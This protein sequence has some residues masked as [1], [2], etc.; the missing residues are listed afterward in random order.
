MSAH[1][2][3]TPNDSPSFAMDDKLA[4]KFDRATSIVP[5]ASGPSDLVTN[6][7]TYADRFELPPKMHEL[8]II[9]G[10]AALVNG[11]VTIRNGAQRIP[12]D[13]WSL[14]ISDSGAGRN[15]LASVFRDLLK[16]CG[17]AERVST[18]GWGSGQAMQEY[19]AKD[20][21]SGTATFH[22]WEEMSAMMQKLGQKS[23]QGA[24]EWIT[25]LYDNFETPPAVRYRSGKGG[26]SKTPD[27][28]F[29]MPPRTNFLALTSE[30]WFLDATNQLQ[31]KGGFTP[32]WCP[33]IVREPGR[34]IATP[35]EADHSLIPPMAEKMKQIA[36]CAGEMRVT[37]PI[38]EDYQRW[39][40]AMKGRFRKHSNPSLAEPFANRHRVHF[41]KLW[42]IYELSSSASLI[43]TKESFERAVVMCRQIEET[44]LT[45]LKTGFSP[46]GIQS[47]QLEDA[48]RAKGPEG[49]SKTE[50]YALGRVS[51]FHEIDGRVKMLIEAGIAIYFQRKS[52]GRGRPGLFLV[53]RDHLKQHEKALPHD[54]RANG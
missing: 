2:S 8:T 22:V 41:L 6:Y 16:E 24:L 32:R 1:T 46:E 45:L 12:L 13:F 20:S 11:K 51:R 42:A 35:A 30:A 14:L 25:N 49:L 7:V 34:F 4:S 38:R 19:F 17:L 43:L 37:G 15:T 54:E 18:D 53:H 40:E 27:I 52:G 39:Y 10:I 3:P 9:A 33:L 21:K 28:V 44:I 47:Q 31:A 50:L 5:G 23:F 48:I 26:K 29:S 36:T